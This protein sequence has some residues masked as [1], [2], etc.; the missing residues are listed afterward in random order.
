M[1]ASDPLSAAL[2]AL[3]LGSVG[4]DGTPSQRRGD[5][6]PHD[7]RR[8]HHPDHG[9]P[10]RGLVDAGVPADGA[11]D[12]TPAADGPLP[13]DS[14]GAPLGSWQ[15]P[16][17]IGA[18]PYTHSA[19]TQSAPADSAN[20]YSCAPQT[21]ESGGEV[22]YQLT[23]AQETTVRVAVDDVAGDGVDVDVHLLTALSPTSCTHRDNIAVE[24]KL[25]SGTHY[26]AVDTWVDSQG[27]VKAGPYTLAVT[28]VSGPSPGGCLQNPL[29]SCKA[30]VFPT[31]NGVPTE[32]AGDPGCPPGMAKVD[33]FCIDRY[34][35]MLVEVKAGGALGPWSPFRSPGSA[36]VRA[37]SVAGAVPQAYINQTQAAAACASAGKRL[38]SDSEWLRACRGSS[39]QTYPYGNTRQPGV[40]NDARS[41]H[42][43]VQYF[44]T[45]ANW[46]WSKLS[47]P[48]IN[49]LPDGLAKTGH[50][51]GCK[52]V[53]GAFD[54]M[55]N[56]HE[57][58][59]NPSGTF[60][61]GFYV[62]TKVNGN[63]CLY[64]TT[65]HNTSYAD[66]STGFRCC[67]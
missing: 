31:V 30:G 39:S 12:Q 56:L 16:I 6:A 13:V 44:E 43:V 61:G 38:C 66:Y 47:H 41:C 50:H 42:P 53:E 55:G 36:T 60:R 32:A 57:W 27:T 51:A 35:A 48:C 2:C 8:I 5:A 64:K 1:R 46:I 24:V 29:P 63:G 45:S 52:T 37:L 62:D 40:C 3:L 18:L 11:A 14:A 65:A 4:C 23:L 25:A 33:T 15:N 7:A 17:P 19:N 26:I 54:M 34:E 9:K 58:T 21:D 59:S 67:K 22:V 20:S 49:Q 28:A 10:D